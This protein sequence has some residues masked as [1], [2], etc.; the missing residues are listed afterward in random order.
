LKKQSQYVAGQMNVTSILTNDYVNTP[1]SEGRE[2]KGKQTQFAGLWPG[3]LNKPNWGQMTAP[4]AHL[5]GYN[6]KKQSQFARG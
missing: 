6:L 2:N 1:R 4:K 5:K 3:I